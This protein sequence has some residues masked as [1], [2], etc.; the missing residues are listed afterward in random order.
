MTSPDRN[1][2]AIQ[3]RN[4]GEHAKADAL[5]IDTGVCEHL[6]PVE[7]YIREQGGRV[8]YVG[9]PWSRNCRNWVYFEGV[10]LDGESLRRRFGLPDFIVVHAHLG[11][12]DGH[13]QGLVCEQHHDA[14]IGP[15]PQMASPGAKVVG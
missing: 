14:L 5:F 6:R 2:L 15:H 3:Y 13:E 4:A 1:Q 7:T 8:T 11:T 12:H 9:S 10:V